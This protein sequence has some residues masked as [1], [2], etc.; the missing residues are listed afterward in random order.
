MWPA[1]ADLRAAQSGQLSAGTA[2]APQRTALPPL[3]RNG[4]SPLHKAAMR[5]RINQ[6]RTQPVAS[7]AFR[8]T[9]ILTHVEDVRIQPDKLPL[10]FEP[11]MGSKRWKISKRSLFGGAVASMVPSARSPSAGP[12]AHHP[13]PGRA[14]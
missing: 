4:S 12:N 10:T 13:P 7:A 2:D 5:D 9:A 6:P 3:T 11:V 8:A 1:A 14:W